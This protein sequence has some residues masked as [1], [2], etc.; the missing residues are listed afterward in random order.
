MKHL[1][2]FLSLCAMLSCNVNV[3]NEDG[4][5]YIENLQNKNSCWEIV[6]NTAKQSNLYSGDDLGIKIWVTARG[7]ANVLD[8]DSVAYNDKIIYEM[9][10]KVCEQTVDLNKYSGIVINCSNNS[11]DSRQISY[12]F[13][14]KDGRLFFIERSKKNYDKPLAPID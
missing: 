1:F 12:E 6:V 8:I 4:I 11:K 5:N 2:L 7:C 13:E 10:E 14:I 9:A 3:L